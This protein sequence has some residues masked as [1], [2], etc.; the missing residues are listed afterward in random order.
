MV[1]TGQM[2]VGDLTSNT[3]STNALITLTSTN[4]VISSAPSTSST[5]PHNQS[6]HLVASVTG[7]GSHRVNRSG[8]G[9]VTI[10][11]DSICWIRESWANYCVKERKT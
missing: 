2:A 11:N 10:L 8:D 4:R 7:V 9:G 6:S 1:M 3:V 5:R